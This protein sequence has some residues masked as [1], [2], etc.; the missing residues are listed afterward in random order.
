MRSNLNFK[1]GTKRMLDL[2]KQIKHLESFL[3]LST[4]FCC[5]E[6][7][8]LAECI[9]DSSHDPYDVMQLIRWLDEEVMD[10]LTPK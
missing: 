6:Q 8:E 4:T 7:K 2:A 5:V 10:H 1:M 3:H 9:V